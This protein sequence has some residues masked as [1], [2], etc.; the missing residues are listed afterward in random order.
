M[1]ANQPGIHG[2][3]L[4]AR[5]TPGGT[6]IDPSSGNRQPVILPP[7]WVSISSDNKISVKPGSINN[8]V[9][10]MN[11]KKLDANPPPSMSVPTGSQ[12]EYM[13]VAKCKGEKAKRFPTE[14]PEILIVP[15]SEASQDT[16]GHGF[17][18]LA[19]LNKITSSE[20][21][22]TW[23]VNQLIGGSVWAERRKLTE[24]NTA[25][26]YFSRI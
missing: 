18:A 23:Q 11:G 20:E 7:F 19:S 12:S 15:S 2:S 4:L 5:K 3:G 13:V 22:V 24:P 8:L 14:D 1:K 26:Y 6:L 9:P 25:F 17:L 21:K 10:T 16:D